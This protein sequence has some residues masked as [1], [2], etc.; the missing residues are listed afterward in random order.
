M[1]FFSAAFIYF[2]SFICARG[3]LFI[4]PMVLANLLSSADYGNLESVQV[5]ASLGA[6][7]L[8]M[9]TINLI[10]LVLVRGIETVSMSAI[11][12]HQFTITIVCLILCLVFFLTNHS[13]L[14]CVSTLA[15]GI[16]LLQAQWSI[17]LKSLG[18]VKAS[19]FLDAGYWAIL[20][21]VTIALYFF[22]PMLE[23]TRWIWIILSLL[24]YWLILACSTFFYYKSIARLHNPKSLYFS[25]IRSGLPLMFAGL[26]SFLA[27]SSGRLGLGL[28][29]GPDM[30]SEYSILYRATAIPIIAHQL[31]IV[32]WYKN[33]FELSDNAMESRLIIVNISGILCVIFFWLI[34][35]PLGFIFGSAFVSVS[36]SNRDTCLLILIQCILWSAIASNDIVNIRKQTAWPV[37]CVSTLY[38]LIAFPLGF[39]Y[40]SINSITLYSFVIIHSVIMVFYFLVQILTMNFYK[41]KLM[42]TW[43]IAF[44]SY[45]I[46]FLFI[47]TYLL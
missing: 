2:L 15:I 9:G 31:L 27:T 13:K 5:F 14:I 16:F 6:T 33:I 23:R 8:S 30:V 42:R 17:T 4:A 3:L 12:N 24:F 1:K 18:R 22:S 19:L 41:I 35:S 32:A 26:L 44:L 38:F 20:A 34:F 47:L 7:L 29:S 10:P 45:L 11:L 25:T 46:L 37:T 43:S 28:L 39:Y 40:I 36:S 21:L